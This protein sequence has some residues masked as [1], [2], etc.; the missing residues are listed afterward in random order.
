VI[1]IEEFDKL[2]VI[3]DEDALDAFD[4]NEVSDIRLGRIL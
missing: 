3:E 4:E 2:D 1:L